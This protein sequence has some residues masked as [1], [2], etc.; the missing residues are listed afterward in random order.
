MRFPKVSLE[1]PRPLRRIVR[2][3]ETSVAA[4]GALVGAVA[5]RGGRHGA[6]VGFLHSAFFGLE[7][8]LRRPRSIHSKLLRSH[9]SAVSSAVSRA[10]GLC[11][12]AAVGKWT[13]SRPN[14]FMGNVCL[15]TEA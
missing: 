11:D 1:A 4:L 9:L 13:Q 3:A 7:A 15:S 2:Q 8:S 12:G 5:P 10:H 6:S 14:A